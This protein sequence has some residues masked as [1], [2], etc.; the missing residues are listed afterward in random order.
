MRVLPILL[1]AALTITTAVVTTPAAQAVT[2]SCSVGTLTEE[3]VPR[4]RPVGRL[5]VAVNRTA[6]TASACFYRVGEATGA[7]A[8]LYVEITGRAGRQTQG[9]AHHNSIGGYAGPVAVVQPTGTCVTASGWIKWKGVKY[10]TSNLK[11]C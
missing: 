5:V 2:G 11:V 7:A 10:E 8:E 1:S 9:P 6:R 4:T 3:S